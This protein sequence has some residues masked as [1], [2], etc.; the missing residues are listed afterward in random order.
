MKIISLSGIVALIALAAATTSAIVR[1]RAGAPATLARPSA[2]TMSAGAV[3]SGRGS[4]AAGGAKLRSGFAQ[5]AS[6]PM[7]DAISRNLQNRINMIVQTRERD[8]RWGQNP[9]L[10]G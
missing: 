8:G 9:R 10:P 6:N 7:A 2:T 4:L 1:P 3:S 5:A